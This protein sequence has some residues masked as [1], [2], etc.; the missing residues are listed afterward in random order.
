MFT[1][2]YTG[3][4]TNLKFYLIIAGVALLFL[5]LILLLRRRKKDDEEEYNDAFHDDTFQ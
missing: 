5:L 4:A 1:G 2:A 3:D